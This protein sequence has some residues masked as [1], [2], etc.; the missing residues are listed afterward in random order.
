[1]QAEFLAKGEPVRDLTVSNPT[2]VGF[3]F[4]EPEI[5]AALGSPG[6]LDYLADARGSTAARLAVTQHLGHGVTPD[7]LLL[8]SSTSEAYAWCFKLLCDP[9]DEV[10]APSP[11][12]PLFEWLARLEGIQAKPVPAWWHDRWNLDLEALE[13]ACG[14][15]TRAV[16][17]V[18]PNNPTGQFIS[19]AEWSGLLELCTRKGLAIVVDE[20]FADYPL[21]PGPED[22]GTVLQDSDPPCT[23]IVLSGLSKVAALPQVKL[24]W[25][26]VRG[27]HAARTLEALEFVADQYLSVSASAQAGASSLLA[28]A[29]ALQ[30]QIRLRLQN[31]LHALDRALSPYPHLARLAVGGGWSV[32]LRRPA[33]TSDEGCA[34][35]LLREARTLVHPGHFFDLP[36]DAYLVLSLLTPESVFA[37]GLGLMLPRL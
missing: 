16:L 26:V 20:V 10:L 31:N 21:E 17:L 23:V 8:T 5:R 28:L 11:S 9:G 32:L 19:R 4:P 3:S 1:M 7:Q 22:L 12:Y 25:A 6:V 14:P 29:P 35:E 30:S 15:R 36:G 37:E 24:G 27:P 18:N 33:T 34:L 13:G 2:R